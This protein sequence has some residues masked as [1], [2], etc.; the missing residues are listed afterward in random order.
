M[1]MAQQRLQQN[2]AGNNANASMG[3]ADGNA[4]V[5]GQSGG[6]MASDNQ[7]HP[8]TQSSGSAVSH[9]GSSSRAQEPERS[10]A[11]GNVAGGDQ[12]QHQA[13]ASGDGGQ[14]TLRRNGALTLI[15]SAFDA[16]KD[17]METLRSK[18]ANLA[19]ELEVTSYSP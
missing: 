11:E 1:A 16:A 18:H 19:S 2:I 3:M 6:Q 9:D 5:A 14:S 13:S 12:T 17:I 8:G 4:R 15:A 10:S 7:L